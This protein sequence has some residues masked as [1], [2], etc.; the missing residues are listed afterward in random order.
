MAKEHKLGLYVGRFQGLHNGHCSAIDILS[1]KCE[2]VLVL[3]GSAQESNTTRNPYDAETRTHILN[4]VYGDNK[5][6]KI[7]SLVDYTDENDICVEWGDYLLRT[8]R[9]IMGEFPDAMISSGDDI[10]G[11]F[12]PHI[13]NQIA[14][15]YLDRDMSATELR[16][17]IAVGNM[18]KVREMTHSA[19]HDELWDLRRKLLE[20]PYYSEINENYIRG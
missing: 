14:K 20:V 8:V 12:E 16:K 11:W 5:N 15:I 13:D 6:V 9:I 18:D 19:I 2:R 1:R 7:A 3:I 4:M 17:A 10:T